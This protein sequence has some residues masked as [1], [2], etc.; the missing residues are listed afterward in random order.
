MT[1]IVSLA[2][3]TATTIPAALHGCVASIGNFDGVHRGH[4]QLLGQAKSLAGE[5]NA[6]TAACVFDPHPI[7]I[8]R[9]DAAPKRLSTIDERAR[10]MNRLGIDFLV[11]I[12]TTPELLSLSAEAFF[13]SL[14]VNN[15]H[16]RGMIEGANFCFGK[17]R[18]GNVDLLTELCAERG[19]QF[20]VA[21]MHCQDED[22]ISSTRIRETLAI[23]DVAA[24]ASMLGVYHRVSGDVRHGDARGRTIGFPTA[25]L[26]VQDVVTPAPG[27]YAGWGILGDSEASKLPAAIHIG[28]SPTFGSGAPE[29]IEVHLLNYNDDLY[30]RTLTVDF[31][32]RVRG[33]ERFGS[34]E[35]LS[36][37]L[38]QDI[39][40]CERLLQ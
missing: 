35:Q 4:A 17:G 36:H 1:E 5:L 34:V 31:V 15:L 38:R 19:I 2:D 8:L 24:A 29:Q 10:R 16:A 7:A 37:Q 33:V 22:V 40:T 26:L 30:G 32:E 3:I 21:E 6:A 28:E 23:G 18:R 25:N 11:V 20:R 13:E 9:P 12:Q 39:Q 27:V 14:L